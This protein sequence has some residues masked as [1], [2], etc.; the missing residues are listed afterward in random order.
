MGPPLYFLLLDGS[1]D[2][3][4][5]LIRDNEPT[6][7]HALWIVPTNGNAQWRLAGINAYSAA[8]SPDGN[9]IAYVSNGSLFLSSGINAPGLWRRFAQAT[10]SAGRPTVSGSG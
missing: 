9:T 2:G 10:V 6:H 1:P 4:R 8:W 3:S 5:L 7:H